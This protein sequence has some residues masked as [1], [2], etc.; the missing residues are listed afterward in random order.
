M[1]IIKES[2]VSRIVDY[3]NSDKSFGVITAY[4]DSRSEEENKMK[5]SELMKR[6]RGAGYGYVMQQGGWTYNGELF[7]EPSIFIPNVSKE[8]L[9][10]CGKDYNQHTVIY[11]D[12]NEFI[13]YSCDTDEPVSTFKKGRDSI[14]TK[15]SS[16]ID[17]YS[18]LMKN[19]KKYVF[20][21]EMLE[22]FSLYEIQRSPSLGQKP[23]YKKIR[24]N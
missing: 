22:D 15:D 19:N 20:K 11:K 3:I 6:V 21:N 2:S 4:S 8:E 17:Y 9:I 24:I 13:E 14:S 10:K 12:D 7:E 16:T 18:K 23:S 5:Q 1:N